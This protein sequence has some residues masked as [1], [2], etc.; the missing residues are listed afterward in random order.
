MS[1]IFPTSFN[2]KFNLTIHQCLP[3]FPSVYYSY[4]IFLNQKYRRSFMKRIIGG[5]LKSG[6]IGG[7][8]CGIISGILNYTIFPFPKSLM[9]HAIG[10]TV[11]GFFCGFFAVVLHIIVHALTRKSEINH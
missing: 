7:M 6:L 10:G 8:V 4:K 5:A 1:E 2:K 3:V 11:G 9:D